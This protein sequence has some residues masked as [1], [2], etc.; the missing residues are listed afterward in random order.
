MANT[1]HDGW[2]QLETSGDAALR[3]REFEPGSFLVEWDRGSSSTEVKPALDTLLS[4]R[5]ALRLVHLSDEGD[6]DDLRLT[7]ELGFCGEGVE[8]TI[9]DD[10]VVVRW[11]SSRL[12]N[13]PGG[14][15]FTAIDGSRPG[16]LV[17]EF[18]Q[19]YD[20]PVL[21]DPAVEPTV[22]F[23]RVHMRMSLIKEEFAELCGAVYGPGAERSLL[24]FF[25]SLPDEH[26][27]D[28]VES[29]DALGDLTYVIYGMALEA[30]I[31]LDQ[32]I[33]EVHRSNLSKLMPDGSVRRRED[34]K[35]LK[36][37]GFTEPDIPGNIR[38]KRN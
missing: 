35:V 33:A 34:G 21:V 36:G 20:L 12:K 22:D 17:E 32:V 24:E 4:H 14:G 28:I 15:R 8:R 13:D 38:R 19:V 23:E 37:P 9:S 16:H 10:E 29:A 3:V 30:G 1:T 5:D 27:R 6:F 26:E 11:R 7:R 18:H 2:V 25:E 31:D